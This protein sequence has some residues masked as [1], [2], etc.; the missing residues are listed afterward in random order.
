MNNNSITEQASLHSDLDKLSVAELLIKIN[1]EDKKVAE[2]VES[3]IPQIKIL[4]ELIAERMSK[5]GRIFYVGA[6]TSGRLGVLDASELPPT[7]GVPSTLVVAVI[8]GGDKALKSAVENAEDDEQ[9]AWQELQHF[10]I[11]NSDTVIGISASGST[12]YVV[13]A[14]KNA[15]KNDILT[16]AITCN[17][18]SLMAKEAEMPIEVIVGPEFVT[19]STRMK[20]GTAQKLVLNMI[21]TATMIKLGRVKG[22]RMVNMQL[23]NNKLIDRGIRMLME[24]LSI[25]YNQ[26]KNLLL[27]NGSVSKAI[28]TFKTSYNA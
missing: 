23:C 13:G 20:A 11:N 28:E 6:G 12:P 21:S 2:V 17:P 22:N 16:A 1:E 8:A 25:E 18:N 15:R 10:S 19:G 14:L 26:A 4:V 9:A 24:E 27:M 3:V 5:G 7:Y